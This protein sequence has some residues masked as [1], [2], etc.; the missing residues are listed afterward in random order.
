MIHF[1]LFQSKNS[2]EKFRNYLIKQH[3][4]INFTS[5]FDENGSLSFLDT[6]ISY[7]NIKFL[8]SGYRKPTF[9]GIFEHFEVG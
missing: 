2:V 3:K 9:S 5:K 1:L 4:N 7:E 6:K 8:T